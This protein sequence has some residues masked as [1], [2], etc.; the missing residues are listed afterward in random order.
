VQVVAISI[1]LT[2]IYN[3]CGGSVLLTGLAH[4]AVNGWPMP[5]SV[6]LQSLPEDARGVPVQVLITAA[7]VLA[8]LLVVVATR[9]LSRTGA[10]RDDAASHKDA[11]A[12]VD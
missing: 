8:A 11:V 2:W 7:T 12:Q 10:S 9:G 1:V 6:A 3:G 5:W 4:A